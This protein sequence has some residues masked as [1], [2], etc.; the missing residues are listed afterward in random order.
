MRIKVWVRI[1]P[2]DGEII[3]YCG[4][5]EVDSAATDDEIGRAVQVW[6]SEH[7]GWGWERA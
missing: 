4:E 3:T 2:D 5:I 6:R 7:A 1:Y